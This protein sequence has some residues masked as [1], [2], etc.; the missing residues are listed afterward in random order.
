[1]KKLLLQLS[2]FPLLYAN[3]ID[4]SI[5]ISYDKL[6]LP[7]GEKL[8]L[9]G[10]SY[11]FDINENFYFGG[12]VYSAVYGKRGGFFTGGLT[13]GV[14][15]PL[16]KNISFESALF[17]GGGGGGSAPQGGG[18][19]LRGFGGLVYDFKDFKAGL[20]ASKIKFPNGNIDSNQIS[21]LVKIPSKELYFLQAP[22]NYNFSSKIKEFKL[23]LQKYH[24]KNRTTLSG[25]KTED[26]SIVG[27]EID[28]QIDKN[29]Y[30]IF[31]A[32]G[33]FDGGADGY[34]EIFFGALYKKKLLDS[35]TL[36]FKA[37]LGGAGGG[38][39]ATGGGSMYK[40][41]S[42]LSYNYHDTSLNIGYG[43][44]D[45]FDG[46]FSADFISASLGYNIEFASLLD[47]TKSYHDYK[48]KEWGISFLTQRYKSN[49]D[50]RKT[51]HDKDIDLLGIKIDRKINKNFYLSATALSAYKGDAGGYAVGLVGA[52]FIYDMN[53]FY[54]SGELQA[55]AGGGG[56]VATGDAL[57]TQ[58]E[59]SLGY[60]INKNLS[61]EL[62]FAKVKANNGSLDSD[63]YTLGVRYKLYFLER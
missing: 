11:L 7:K 32:G 50:M 25:T 5:D 28:S 30:S 59:I 24:P 62:K 9:V 2:F 48:A 27:M 6:T 18:L 42:E 3:V 8:G 56:G 21:F 38:R 22:K 39:V 61:T 14:K 35:L 44:I 1:M 36:N 52:G 37:M 60:K 47:R 55:G 31:Q 23:Q 58:P 12:S 15:Y 29:I 16:S 33:A 57:I 51:Y 49:K 63:V 46:K 4:S 13:A 20:G 26:I 40:V 19:M 10:T 17:C 43:Y 41:E 54:L 53:N 45:S 34:A